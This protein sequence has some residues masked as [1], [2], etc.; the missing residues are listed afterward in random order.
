MDIED[1]RKI[2]SEEITKTIK[3]NI[4]SALIFSYINNLEKELEKKDKI[5]DAMAETFSGISKGKVTIEEDT[6][7]EQI[8]KYFTKKVEENENNNEAKM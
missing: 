1:L 4:D 2:A 7:K 3:D 6:E 5:I 8:I